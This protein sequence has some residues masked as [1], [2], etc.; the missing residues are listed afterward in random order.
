MSCVDVDGFVGCGVWVDCVDYFV[1]VYSQFD[2]FCGVS[3]VEFLCDFGGFE[4]VVLG[5]VGGWVPGEVFWDRFSGWDVRVQD[6]VLC[7]LCVVFGCWDDVRLRSGL[8][9]RFLGDLWVGVVRGLFG[10]G[11]LGEFCRVD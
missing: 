5:F 2:G 1:D 9:S 6:F 8:C 4:F 3:V 10:D 7:L 11:L